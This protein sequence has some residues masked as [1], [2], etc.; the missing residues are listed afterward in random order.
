ME[1]EAFFNRNIFSLFFFVAEYDPL[2]I[3][4][5]KHGPYRKIDK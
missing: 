5:N 3:N 1:K 2:D 4:D